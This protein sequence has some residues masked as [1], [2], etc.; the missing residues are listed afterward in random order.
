M[1]CRVEVTAKAKRDLRT[2]RDRLLARKALAEAG[3]QQHA[4]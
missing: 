4:T 1:P 3:F 2:I